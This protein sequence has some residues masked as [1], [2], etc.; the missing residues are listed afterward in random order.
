MPT[1]RWFALVMGFTAGVTTMMANAAGPV[2][3]VYLLAMQLPKV[4]FA[5]TSAWFFFIIN[6][7]KVPFSRNLNL[8]TPEG[9]KL[10]LMTLPAIAAGALIGI[11]F[12]KR[13]PQKTFNAVVQ[14]LAALAALRL[15]LSPFL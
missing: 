1:Q 2:M 10:D 9:L 8:I 6:W 13:I 12:L 15:L 7:S 4:A 11:F 5:G 14:I 3:T